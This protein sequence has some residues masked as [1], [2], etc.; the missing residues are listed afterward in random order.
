MPYK[1]SC[2]GYMTSSRPESLFQEDIEDLVKS[3]PPQNNKKEPIHL[4]TAVDQ[5]SD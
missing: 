1:A 5:R 2:E 3:P 4:S